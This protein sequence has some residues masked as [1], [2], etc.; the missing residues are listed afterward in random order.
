MWVDL[1]PDVGLVFDLFRHLFPDFSLNKMRVYKLLWRVEPLTGEKIIEK[2]GLAKSTTYSIL[3]ELVSLG[4]VAKTNFKPVGYY[5]VDPLKAYSSNYVRVMN[6]LKKGKNKVKKIINNGTSLS[7]EEYLIRIN[8]GQRKL[9][10][11]TTKQTNLNEHQLKE[12]R[13]IIDEELKQVQLVKLKPWQL[14]GRVL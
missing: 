8:G 3:N 1:D 2:I 10:N 9:F 5:A 6:K 13:K 11:K 12:L 7:G 14:Q 4:L